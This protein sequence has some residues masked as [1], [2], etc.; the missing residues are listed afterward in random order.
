VPGERYNLERLNADIHLAY[1][2]V[3]VRDIESGKVR[4]TQDLFGAD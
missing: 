2:K 3:K 1:P 4:V